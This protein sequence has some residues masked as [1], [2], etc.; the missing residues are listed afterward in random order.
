MGAPPPSRGGFGGGGGFKDYVDDVDYQSP[1]T[2][3]DRF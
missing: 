2:G 1:F 3:Q